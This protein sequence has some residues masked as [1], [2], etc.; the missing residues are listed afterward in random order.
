MSDENHLIF[1]LNNIKRKYSAQSIFFP[2]FVL[3][4]GWK[5]LSSS[6]LRTWQSGNK[7][8]FA[9]L[10]KVYDNKTTIG[11]FEKQTGLII[12]CEKCLCLLANQLKRDLK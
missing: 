1:L 10:K 9:L 3:P 5:L 8:R 12:N 4:D 6:W 2:S 7:L 11:Y